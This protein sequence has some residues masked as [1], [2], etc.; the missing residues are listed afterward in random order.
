MLIDES[1]SQAKRLTL[2]QIGNQI[3]HAM[4][5]KS[6]QLLERLRHYVLFVAAAAVQPSQQSV[7]D[8]E[9]EGQGGGGGDEAAAEGV[10]LQQQGVPPAI[11]GGNFIIFMGS[12]GNRGSK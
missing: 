4:L 1:W 2:G 7:D 12:I 6:P 11:S 5:A 3:L 8:E 10:P 9:G